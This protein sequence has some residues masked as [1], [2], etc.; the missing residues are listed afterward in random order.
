[1]IV[2][3]EFRIERVER[4][5]PYEPA[6]HVPVDVQPGH[7]GPVSRNTVADG[8]AGERVELSATVTFHRMLPIKVGWVL[9]DGAGC[10]WTVES[11]VARATL[12]VAMTR[13]DVRRIIGGAVRL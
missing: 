10:E 6:R 7:M 9:V 11:V 3:D 12:G 8:G 5:E 2:T 1:M 4:P 13:C